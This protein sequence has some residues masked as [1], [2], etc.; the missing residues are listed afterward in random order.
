MKQRP[1]RKS[2][3]PGGAQIFHRIYTRLG[4]QGRPPHFVVEFYPYA[5]LM[6]TIRVK[7]QAAQVRLCDVLRGA[8]LEILEAAAAILLSRIYQRQAPEELLDAYRRFAVAP[9]TRR[10]VARLR[11]ARAPV[12]QL[13][14]RGETYD[15]AS[16]FQ[17][18]NKRYFAGQLPKPHLGWS[19]RNWR[20]QFGCFDPALN[21]IVMNRWLDRA[22]VPP[23]VVEYVLFHE[24]LHVK[25]PMRAARC[26]IESHSSSFRREEKHYEHYDRARK[27]LTR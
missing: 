23:Y 24:M 15:L 20:T 12:A 11:K 9:R 10:N 17:R 13:K 19:A 16:M 14:P 6:H 1:A 21:Q 2:F 7:D 8:P 27:F 25:H 5:N 22:S 4:C 18:L 3:V 26:G